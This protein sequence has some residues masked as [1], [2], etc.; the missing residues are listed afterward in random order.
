MDNKLTLGTVHIVEWLRPGDAR[1]GW[2]LFDELEPLGIAS[3]PEV[4]VKFWRAVTRDDFLNLLRTFEDEFRASARTPLLHIETH[5]NVDGIGVSHDEG[6]NWPDLMEVL[7]AFNRLTRLNLVVILA[8]CEGFWGVQMLQLDRRA[9]AFR[10]LIGP[11]RAVRTREMSD[12]CMAFYRT[13]FGQLN[14]DTALKAVND[15]VN[16]AEKT[17]WIISAETAFKT[18]YQGYLDKQCTPEAIEK[19]VETIVANIGARLR[20]EGR[21]ARFN[22][23]IE[24]NRETARKHLSDHRARFEEMRREFFFIDLYPENAERF[25]F[26]FEDCQPRP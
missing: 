9:A 12:G 24:R 19:R 13:L 3:R 4:Q 22:W 20:A 5:G 1:T 11:N 14:G 21:P 23:E 16:P 25:D 15:A 10:G 18:V 17:F 2:E 8:A 7:V 26:T 6:I